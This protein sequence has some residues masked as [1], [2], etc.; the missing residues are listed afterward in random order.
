MAKYSVHQYS[1]E[2]LLAWIKSGE[3]A[4]P[5]IQ[6]PFVWN[7]SKVRDLIDSLYHGYPVG[8]IITW[9]NPDQRLKD[10]SMSSGK[11][12]L[13]D[14]QQRITALTAAVVGQSVLNK[15]YKHT[16]IK[17][18]YNPQATENPFEVCNTAIERN[19]IWISDISPILNGTIKPSEV[20]KTYLAK[21]PSADEDAIEEKITALQAITQRQIGVIELNH[22]LDIDTVTEIFIRI[23]QKGVVLSNADF[24][25]S[26][27][28]SDQQYGGNQLRKM[29]DYF[30]H[31][32]NDGSFQNTIEE[33][34]NEFFQSADYQK[35]KWISK[36]DNLYKP[37]YIDVLRV[38]YTYVFGRGKFSDLVA[39]LSGRDFDN[40]RHLTE[41][42]A[43]SYQKLRT[44]LEACF[45]QTNYERFLVL[46]RSAGFISNKLL[47][48]QN[49]LNVAYAIYLQLKDANVSEIEI[50][51]LVKKWLVMSILTGRYSGSSESVI[52]RDMKQIAEKGLS[53]YLQQ[54][55]L[56][57]LN[58]GFWTHGLVNQLDSS[59]NLSGP[60]LCYLAAQCKNQEA[61]FL[62]NSVKV[63]DLLQHRGDEHHVFPKNHLIQQNYKR[64]EYNQIANFVLIEQQINIRLGDKSPQLYWQEVLQDIEQQSKKYTE[65]NSKEKLAENCQLNC[66]PEN[67]YMLSYEDFLKA[68]RKLMA[69]KIQK[70][71]F[72]L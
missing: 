24:V 67:F 15:D 14:G 54:I 18:A 44:G 63:I 32:L 27:I 62:S 59:S 49:S 22:D 40:R 68:R 6:R 46:V 60:Y 66:I 19:P 57:E 3:I 21:N 45:N 42:A 9:R 36:G 29:I 8:F 48:S 33:N 50:Q 11:R 16:K 5:E 31:L 25:M 53:E 28:A 35:I 41:I 72:S 58:N 17:I 30:C 38:A 23:N 20:R 34:D 56:A 1:I 37:N 55:E 43:Q 39:L 12:I 7:A 71:Y 70:F 2:I 26:K 52:E 65:L 13:I 64:S 47:S 61:A 4:I 51:H 10:G 69:N